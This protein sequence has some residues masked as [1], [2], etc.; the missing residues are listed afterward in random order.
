MPRG[1]IVR[2]I[3]ISYVPVIAVSGKEGA[4][5]ATVESDIADEAVERQ[6][7]AKLLLRLLVRHGRLA[8]LHI[9]DVAVEVARSEVLRR[10][11]GC[12]GH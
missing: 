5:Y 4:T 9:L 1:C 7:P 10:G 8:A 3:L 2:I 12:R 6:E 11:C